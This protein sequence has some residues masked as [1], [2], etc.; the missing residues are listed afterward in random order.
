MKK[1]IRIILVLFLVS[2]SALVTLADPPT[3][4][5]PGDGNGP[6]NDNYVGAPIDHGL[7]LLILFAAVLGGYKLYSVYKAKKLASN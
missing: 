6:T 4:P 1:T 7:V 2:Y 5:N 3:P